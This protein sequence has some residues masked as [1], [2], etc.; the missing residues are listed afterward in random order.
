MPFWQTSVG[1][2]VIVV[3]LAWVGLLGKVAF[4]SEEVVLLSC[5]VVGTT[6]DVVTVAVA[7]AVAVFSG[8]VTVTSGVVT[9]TS[10]V[11][12]VTSGVV[13]L[14]PAVVGLA[15]EVTGSVGEVV[16]PAAVVTGSVTAAVLGPGSVVV[17]KV[18]M[19]ED[20][21]VDDGAVD[22]VVCVEG[23]VDVGDR[24]HTQ[25]ATALNAGALPS[26]HCDRQLPS[27]RNVA[28]WHMRQKFAVQL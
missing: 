3:L 8:V 20:A 26:G 6:E 2:G 5:A 27:D 10:G 11:V 1:T 12:T 14:L 7:V 22:S 4:A 24:P 17:T 16:F 9:V 21:A 28:P 25:P 15:G 23:V 18:D 19:G 13:S